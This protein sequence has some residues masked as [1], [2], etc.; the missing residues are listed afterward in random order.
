M[1][2]LDSNVQ[3][4]QLDRVEP[5]RDALGPIR[6]RHDMDER[7]RDLSGGTRQRRLGW[8]GWH[9]GGR[10]RRGVRQGGGGAELNA[11]GHGR[12]IGGSR[13]ENDLGCVQSRPRGRDLVL[14]ESLMRRGRR[15]GILGARPSPRLRGRVAQATAQDWLTRSGLAHPR[16][17]SP[18]QDYPA[19]RRPART[20]LGRLPEDRSRPVSAT[21]PARCLIA[22][23]RRCCPAAPTRRGGRAAESPG[24]RCSHGP[25]HVPGPVR[26]RAAPRE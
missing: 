5:Y 13:W 4:T 20:R 7:W 26:V 10:W 3:L 18:R 14:R 15:R 9:S 12:R 23:A 6:R 22:L 25:G 2:T 11:A 16:L 8:A 24:A 19:Q 21:G 17:R 1:R